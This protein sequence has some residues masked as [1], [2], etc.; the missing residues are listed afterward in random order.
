MHLRPVPARIA[1]TLLL[2]ALAGCGKSLPSESQNRGAGVTT[3]SGVG[4]LAT[5]G[6]ATRNTT[7]LGGASP[8]ADA[9]AVALAV[10]PGLTPATRLKRRWFSSTRTTGPRRSPRRHSKPTPGRAA[11]LQRR[12]HAAR[13]LGR[14]ARGDEAAR[15][16]AAWRSAGDRDRDLG[17][18][19]RLSHALARYP[20]RP[21][22][23]GRARQPRGRSQRHSRRGSSDW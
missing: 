12:Q 1:A 5:S 15:L 16:A 8:L 14:G 20:H 6:L 23:Y 11:A 22:R 18:S 19:R 7:R 21:H 13:D 4:A 10:N 2:G 9:A 17:G 3:V